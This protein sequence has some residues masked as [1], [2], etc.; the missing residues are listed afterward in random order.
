M[1]KSPAYRKNFHSPAPWRG[2]VHIAIGSA[3]AQ[4]VELP[5]EHQERE[6][7]SSGDMTPQRNG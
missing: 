7:A 5:I 2:D 3:H 4:P 1:T 6:V